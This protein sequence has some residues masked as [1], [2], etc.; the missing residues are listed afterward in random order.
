MTNAR[1]VSKRELHAVLKIFATIISQMN[2]KPVDGYAKD[3]ESGL[4][5]RNPVFDG[6]FYKVLARY[7]GPIEN[8]AFDGIFL[9]PRAVKA[10]SQNGD[11]PPSAKATATE[12]KNPVFNGSF[13]APRPPDGP[14]RKPRFDGPYYATDP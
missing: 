5:I 4:V 10:S 1:Q 13:F 12:I 6:S 8:P 14:I 11:E 9:V 2:G 7:A 3:V